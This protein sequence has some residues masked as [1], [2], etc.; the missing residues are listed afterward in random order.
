MLAAAGMVS[1]VAV[2]SKAL[3]MSLSGYPAPQGPTISASV[4][5]AFTKRMSDLIVQLWDSPIE[6]DDQLLVRMYP[7]R[8]L[9]PPHR[10]DGAIG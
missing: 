3:H 6:P 8:A 5:T 1:G 2:D 9:N 7:S 4:E 10:H